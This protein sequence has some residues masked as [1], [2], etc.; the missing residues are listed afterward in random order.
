ME[1]FKLP[2]NKIKVALDTNILSYLLDDTYESLN[3]L[4]QYFNSIDFVEIECSNFVLYEL[5]GVRKLEH[6]I[7]KLSDESKKGKKKVNFSSLFRYRS[8]WNAP[9]LPYSRCSKHVKTEV[10]KELE[11]LTTGCSIKFTG[12]IHKDVWE[13]H[14][15]FVLSSKL[16]KEDCMVLMSSVFPHIGKTQD[17]LLFFT[18]DEDFYNAYNQKEDNKTDINKVFCDYSIN[19]PNVCHIKNIPCSDRGDNHLDLRKELNGDRIKSFANIFVFNHL[20]KANCKYYLGNIIK[21]KSK[22]DNLLC[23]RLYA[24]QLNK[25][26]YLTIVTK[27]LQIVNI[28]KRQKAFWSHGEITSFP[29][30]PT[31][32]EDSRE[33]SIRLLDDSGESLL[34]QEEWSNVKVNGNLV[35]IHPDS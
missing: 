24:D 15:D 17:N 28:P 3:L 35:F 18:N 23:F 9:E 14:K 31:E 6:Y 2:F 33:I 5:I 21:C 27:E 29:Y 34:S 7:R 25:D 20:K 13:P 22:K 10:E 4:V 11:Q 30:S 32:S 8:K 12:D 16:S 1:T 26:I 19:K